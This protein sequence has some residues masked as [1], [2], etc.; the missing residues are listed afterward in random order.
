M[1]RQSRGRWGSRGD[2]L[3]VSLALG[4]L[5]LTA[6]AYAAD[7]LMVVQKE[8]YIRKDKKTLSPKVATVHEKDLVT[9]LAEEESWY[10]VEWNGVQGWLL[11]TAVTADL[12]TL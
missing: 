2:L 8:A 11:R 9:K 4:V 10:Q 5:T 6:V 3:V 1:K 7:L 12:K